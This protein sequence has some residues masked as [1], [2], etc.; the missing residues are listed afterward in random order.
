VNRGLS[1]WIKGFSQLFI[2]GENAMFPL[3]P[4]ALSHMETPSGEY[5]TPA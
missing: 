1:P 3:R 2:D 5:E 4:P